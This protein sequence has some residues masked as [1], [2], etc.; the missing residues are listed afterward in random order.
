MLCFLILSSMHLF[1]NIAFWVENLRPAL[2][3]GIDSRNRVWNWTAKLYIGWRAYAY[4]VHIAPKAGLK[5][6]K[7]ISFFMAYVN[8]SISS[9]FTFIKNIHRILSSEGFSDLEKNAVIYVCQHVA[10]INGS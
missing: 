9:P 1:I 6:P 8:Y 4:L 3:R 5:L 2:G 7:L 10:D